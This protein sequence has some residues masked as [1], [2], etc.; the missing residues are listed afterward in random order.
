MAT[1]AE[2]VTDLGTTST[3]PSSASSDGQSV[4][5][6]GIADKIL[7]IQFQAANSAAGLR[8]RGI[9]YSKMTTAPALS[10]N[11]LA[12]SRAFDGGLL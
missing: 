9:R 3:G 8:R 4:T 11:N 12:G 1:I 5:D 7:A 10:D 2:Q 6:R